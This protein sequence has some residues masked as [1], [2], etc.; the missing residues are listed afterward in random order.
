MEHIRVEF[1]RLKLE[2]KNVVLPIGEMGKKAGRVFLEMLYFPIKIVE[3]LRPRK[4]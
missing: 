3:N 4:K 2:S 1:D